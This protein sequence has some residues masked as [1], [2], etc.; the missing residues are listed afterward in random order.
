M[1]WSPTAAFKHPLVGIIKSN[2]EASLTNYLSYGMAEVLTWQGLGGLTNR[3]RTKRLKL[4]ELANREGP[5]IADYLKIPYMYC[6]S[7]N[8]IPKPADWKEH[9]D[10][11]GY[12][13]LEDSDYTPD[14]VLLDFLE[15][16]PTP[17]YIG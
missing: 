16:G 5:G 3:F 6:W 12:Y 4:R 7:P 17:I 8:L 1:P 9:I 11:S 15:A 14:A 10:V 2:A 13:F